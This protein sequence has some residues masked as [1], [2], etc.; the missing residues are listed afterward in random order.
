MPGDPGG[1]FTKAACTHA[2][3][4]WISRWTGS[5]DAIAVMCNVVSLAS[6]SDASRMQLV[7]CL[8]V[9]VWCTKTTSPSPVCG[10]KN[11]Q[12]DISSAW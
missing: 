7:Q 11:T 9:A 1:G 12:A 4:A 6:N 3:A 2:L 8:Q 10:N 5:V